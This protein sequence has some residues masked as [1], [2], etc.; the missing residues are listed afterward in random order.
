MM[1]AK[2]CMQGVSKLGMTGMKNRTVRD[3]ASA[4]PAVE[5]AAFKGKTGRFKVLVSSR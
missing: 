4:N 1:C 5:D 3:A 2:E